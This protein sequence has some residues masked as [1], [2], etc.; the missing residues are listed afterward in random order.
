[1]TDPRAGSTRVGSLCVLACV[2]ALLLLAWPS[3]AGA[4]AAYPPSTRDGCTVSTSTVDAGPGDT[5]TLVGSGFP[6]DTVVALSIPSASA[7]LGSVTTAADGTFSGRFTWPASVNGA[8]A[9]VQAMTAS[10][11]CSFTIT[12]ADESTNADSSDGSGG[13]SSTG[14]ATLTATTIA[15]ALI[16]AGAIFLGLARRRS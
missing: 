2:C 13:L 11:I 3:R 10:K 4:D 8:S 6:A 5:I 12:N 14:F 16:G 1:M 15:I 7:A 9:V